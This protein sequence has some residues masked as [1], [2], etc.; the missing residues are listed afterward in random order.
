MHVDVAQFFL[1]QIEVYE[2]FISVESMQGIV[3]FYGDL[4]MNFLLKVILRKDHC[5][6]Q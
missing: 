5:G 2:L 4:V 6:A 1:R 3:K